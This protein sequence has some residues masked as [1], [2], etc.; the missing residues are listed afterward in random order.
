MDF[1]EFKSW[2]LI[3]LGLLVFAVALVYRL[4]TGRSIEQDWSAQKETRA[5]RAEER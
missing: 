5:P 4:V 3:A 1:V 2:K